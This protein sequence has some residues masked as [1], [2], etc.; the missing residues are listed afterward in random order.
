MLREKA[1][2]VRVERILSGS[3][4][5]YDVSLIFADLRF[6][7][8]CPSEISDLPHFAA[9]RHERDKGHTF[10]SSN[11]LLT[12]L[13]AYLTGKQTTWSADSGYNVVGIVEY[14]K[15]Y[16]IDNNI[17]SADEL[18][19]VSALINPIALYGLAAMHGC[20]FKQKN[21]KLL[22][23]A[24]RN[25]GGS[26]EIGMTAPRKDRPGNVNLCVFYTALDPNI[27]IGSL[28]DSLPSS[29]D[30]NITL[31]VTSDGKL[32]YLQ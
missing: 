31:E 6:L 18:T 25:G 14:L 4:S 3:A 23:L 17:F 30:P 11:K 27:A 12:N 15:K 22:P 20:V 1:I 16:L 9:H 10:D 28:R 5:P 13:E 32:Q 26:L 29:S 24:I 19:D 8:D 7:I 2:R 21:A